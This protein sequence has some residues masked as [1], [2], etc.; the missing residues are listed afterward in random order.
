MKLEFLTDESGEIIL[1]P[2]DHHQFYSIPISEWELYS[3]DKDE[4][5]YPLNDGAVRR[6]IIIKVWQM[7]E[8]IIKKEGEP[9]YA[10]HV[11]ENYVI[12]PIDPADPHVDLYF[13]YKFENNGN[14]VVIKGST[15]EKN[16]NQ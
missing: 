15:K 4:H 6:N 14:T 16:P 13:I 2:D 7:M 5:L 3:I 12:N 10:P 11:I 9:R 8:P 1:C